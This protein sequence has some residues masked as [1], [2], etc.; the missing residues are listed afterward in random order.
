LIRSHNKETRRY[1]YCHIYLMR[2]L[3][4][5]IYLNI[6]LHITVNRKRLSYKCQTCAADCVTARPQL[7]EPAVVEPSNQFD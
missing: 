7:S 5:Q 4:A 3:V 2:F 1:S 6:I